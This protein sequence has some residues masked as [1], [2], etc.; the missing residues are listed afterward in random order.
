MRVAT[1]FPRIT[2]RFFAERGIDVEV[3]PVSGAAEIA[4]HIGIADVIVEP[5]PAAQPIRIAA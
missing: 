2:K 1:V 3:V 5:Q 4:P